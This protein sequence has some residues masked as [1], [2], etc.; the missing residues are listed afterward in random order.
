MRDHVGTIDHLI[1]LVLA[2]HWGRLDWALR[3]TFDP[4]PGVG[5]VSFASHCSLLI[6]PLRNTM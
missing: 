6:S 2:D 5:T 4:L 3:L 1:G